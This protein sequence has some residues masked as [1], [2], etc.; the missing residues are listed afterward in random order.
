MQIFQR[1]IFSN[2]IATGTVDITTERNYSTTGAGSAW[3]VNNCDEGSPTPQCYLWAIGTTC[4]DE[5]QAM[6]INGAGTV[7]NFILIGSY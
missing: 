3:A 5:P 1:A 2:D 6:L 7:R 4:T